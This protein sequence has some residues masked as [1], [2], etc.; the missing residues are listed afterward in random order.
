MTDDY[1]A[2]RLYGDWFVGFN[3]MPASAALDRTASGVRPSLRPMTRVGVFCAAR[4]RSAPTSSD[5]QV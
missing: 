1:F 2:R 5:F 3:E 4:L